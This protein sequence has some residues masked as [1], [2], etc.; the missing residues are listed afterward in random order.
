MAEEIF[1][2]FLPACHTKTRN[3]GM[4]VSCQRKDCP[5]KSQ[6]IFY[7]NSLLVTNG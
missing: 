7:D 5:I 6:C 2:K 3:G 4:R 1:D